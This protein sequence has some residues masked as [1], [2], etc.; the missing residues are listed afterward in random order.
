VITSV[1]ISI[2]NDI[3]CIIMWHQPFLQLESFSGPVHS[4]LFNCAS[5][6]WQ[7]IC[8]YMFRSYAPIR[9][10]AFT[11][12]RACKWITTN[13]GL[14]VGWLQMGK[15]DILPFQGRSHTRDEGKCCEISFW[16][17]RRTGLCY[18]RFDCGCVIKHIH[19]ILF[20]NISI[21]CASLLFYLPTDLPICMHAM[22]THLS[23]KCK[24][25]AS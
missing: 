10:H 23:A 7:W 18:Q 16:F 17:R 14:F 11:N 21:L 22:Y 6:L 19:C 24:K 8:K 3:I 9:S 2:Y 25:W 20:L 15:L 5:W 4:R 1:I 12:L 13:I